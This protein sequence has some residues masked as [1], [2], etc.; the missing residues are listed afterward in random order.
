MLMAEL[1]AILTAGGITPSK[2]TSNQVLSALNVMYQVAALD[3]G[4]KY[5]MGT[6]SG[7]LV[8]IEQ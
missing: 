1:L 3:A 2:T 8:Q 6:A 7:C 5:R 4:T